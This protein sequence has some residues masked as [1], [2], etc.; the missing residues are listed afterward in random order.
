MIE[1][2][3]SEYSSY[4]IVLEEHRNYVKYNEETEE[5]TFTLDQ[6]NNL[7]HSTYEDGILRH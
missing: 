1:I 3:R 4:N 5:I 7:L 6:L 2:D